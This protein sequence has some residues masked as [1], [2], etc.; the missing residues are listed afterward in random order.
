MVDI[1][2]TVQKGCYRVDRSSR[3]NTQATRKLVTAGFPRP[4][5]V[6]FVG[7]IKWR[8]ESPFTTTDLSALERDIGAIPGVTVDTPRVAVARSRVDA[9][10]VVALT[11]TEIVSA[12]RPQS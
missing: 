3:L 12:W 7:S 8:E 11:A 2:A 10:G 5:S 9:A 1:A 4:A 6:G